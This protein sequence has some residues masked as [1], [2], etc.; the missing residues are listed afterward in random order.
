MGKR[1]RAE[2]ARMFSLLSKL[3]AKF[4]LSSLAIIYKPVSEFKNPPIP[5]D[6][7]KLVKGLGINATDLLK[8][9][10]YNDVNAE[11]F[12]L[13]E[14]LAKKHACPVDIAKLHTVGI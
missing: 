10:H 3:L 12:I 1:C 13:A 6:C 14:K 5:F 7:K 8:N 9:P 11:G 2:P 4:S